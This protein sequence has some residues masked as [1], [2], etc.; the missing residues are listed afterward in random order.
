MKHLLLIGAPG[1]GKG[2][3]AKQLTE[4]VQ[5]STGD[6]LRAEKS[7][8]TELGNKIAKLIDEGKFVDNDT[9][10]E[11]LKTNLP[12]NK[13]LIFDGYPRNV[14]QIKYFEQLVNIEDVIIIHFDVDLNI[15]EDRIVNRSTCKDCGEIHNTLSNPPKKGACNKCGGELSTRKDDNA[16][17]LVTRLE[18]YK[19]KTL[20]VMEYY[21][22]SPNFHSVDGSRSPEEVLVEVNEILK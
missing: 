1:A 9:M 2:T 5:I 3:L 8:G 20:P 16:E 13:Q 6:I 21:K 10:L 7:K 4:Y 17:A 19:V 18:D 22:N 14:E 12:E 11:L 15:I